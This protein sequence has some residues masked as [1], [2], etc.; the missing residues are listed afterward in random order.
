MKSSRQRDTK[1]NTAQK[2]FVTNDVECLNINVSVIICYT[3]LVQPTAYNEP[4]NE[5]N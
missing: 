5:Y 2:S 1:F 4:S 3:E